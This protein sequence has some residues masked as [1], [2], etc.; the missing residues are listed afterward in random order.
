MNG[1]TASDRRFSCRRT[2]HAQRNGIVG[3]LVAVS[4]LTASALLS[5]VKANASADG[6][7]V[8]VMKIWDRHGF[9][10]PIVASRILA[11]AGL[12]PAGGIRWRV[13]LNDCPAGHTYD[14]VATSADKLRAVQLAP[15]ERWGFSS[16]TGSVGQG[17]PQSQIDNARD[18]LISWAKRERG[19][20]KVLDYRDR[21]DRAKALQGFLQPMSVGGLVNQKSA[22]A[23]DLL[24]GYRINNQ[25]VRES[26]S[27][28]IIVDKT[29]F[30][31]YGMGSP[32]WMMTGFSMPVMAMRMPAG[33][34]NFVHM[35]TIWNSLQSNPAWMQRINKSQRVISRQNLE[36]ARKIGEI[37]RKSAEDLR[38]IQNQTYRNQ[39][40]S[41]DR[42]QRESLE[43]IRHTET[44]GTTG[45]DAVELPFTSHAWQLDDGSFY[46]SDSAGFSP[47]DIGMTGR[48]LERRQ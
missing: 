17:C 38:R 22:S 13:G 40:E 29:Q 21:P 42:M 6:M 27:G 48:K 26:L 45:G 1:L 7:H 33:K 16:M 35:E 37:N 30:P 15:T 31:T 25:P 24:I 28:T 44:W 12:K 11:P 47:S 3:W 10:K 4:A 36:S 32:Q 8:Q 14:W 9:K 20:I 41:S 23:G 39:T 5:P 2:G 18:F 46:I 34:L 43:A 19:Q